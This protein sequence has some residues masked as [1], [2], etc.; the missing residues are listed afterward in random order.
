MVQLLV[1]TSTYLFKKKDTSG[2]QCQTSLAALV[3]SSI[4]SNVPKVMSL[5][6]VQYPEETP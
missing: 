2:N 4:E 3:K 5:V 6:W 1:K